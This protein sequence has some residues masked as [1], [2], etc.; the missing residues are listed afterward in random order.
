MMVQ[1][2]LPFSGGGRMI[3]LGQADSRRLSRGLTACLW[4]EFLSFLLHLSQRG[5]GGLNAFPEEPFDALDL[6]RLCFGEKADSFRL[7]VK[8]V[9]PCVAVRITG[10]HRTEADFLGTIPV[11][12]EN[13]E[14]QNFRLGV[15]QAGPVQFV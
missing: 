8:P 4:V 5:S 11:N 12:A 9:P 10:L 14:Q 1:S 2:S 13:L 15:T 7:Q 3:Y 6:I